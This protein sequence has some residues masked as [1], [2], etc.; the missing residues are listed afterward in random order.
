MVDRALWRARILYDY[1]QDC[2]L[3]EQRR[4]QWTDPACSEGAYPALQGEPDRWNSTLHARQAKRSTNP[5]KQPSRGSE[6]IDIQWVLLVVNTALKVLAREQPDDLW[7][8]LSDT[9]SQVLQGEA[10]EALEHVTTYIHAR[11]KFSTR[12]ALFALSSNLCANRWRVRRRSPQSRAVNNNL[13]Q[14]TVIITLDSAFFIT[15]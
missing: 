3:S 12:C 5:Q 15:R 11:C 10:L 8:E 2:N 13:H 4:G 1:H 14:I 6:G 9:T 7:E